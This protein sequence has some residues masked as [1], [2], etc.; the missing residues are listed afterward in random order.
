MFMLI[1][2]VWKWCVVVTCERKRLYIMIVETMRYW[3]LCYS[4]Y[5][6]NVRVFPYYYV[7][8]GF[9]THYFVVLFSVWRLYFKYTYPG[10]RGVVVERF[11]RWRWRDSL[12][13][14][15]LFGSWI[16]MLIKDKKKVVILVLYFCECWIKYDNKKWRMMEIDRNGNQTNFQSKEDV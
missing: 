10:W 14:V 4:W 2:Y 9:L 12:H 6:F 15:M 3:I 1:I 13:L 7:M 11:R 16:V 5:L 8:A